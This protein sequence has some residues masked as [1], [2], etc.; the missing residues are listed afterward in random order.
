MIGRSVVELL[1]KTDC[2]ILTVSL[3]RISIKNCKHII[4]DLTDFNFCKKLQKIMI[5]FFI[6]LE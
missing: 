6:L 4:G 5:M 1:K 3:D 2:K